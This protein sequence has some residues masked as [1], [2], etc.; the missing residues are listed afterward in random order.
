[1]VQ[2]EYALDFDEWYEAV[3]QLSL[4]KFIWRYVIWTAILVTGIV[5][6]ASDLRH[7]T[8]PLVSVCNDLRRHRSYDDPLGLSQADETV[9]R[10]NTRDK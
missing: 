6:L 5:M 1:M 2:I 3:S 9:L 4:R 8:T 7:G 10:S